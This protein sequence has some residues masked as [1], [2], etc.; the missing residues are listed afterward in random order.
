M[1][2][3]LPSAAW[4]EDHFATAAGLHIASGLGRVTGAVPFSVAEAGVAILAVGGAILGFR[5]WRASQ[6]RGRLAFRFVLAAAC[7]F[8]LG[9]AVF[10]GSWGLNYRR[11]PIAGAFGLPVEK[12]NADELRTLAAHFF[13]RMELARLAAPTRN[14]VA[15][16]ESGGQTSIFRRAAEAYHA[17]GQGFPFLSGDYSPAKPLLSSVLFSYAGVGGIYVPFTAE[18]HVNVDSPDWVLPFNVCHEMAHQRGVAREDEANYVGFRVARD[19]GSP[20]FVYSA[21]FG[22]DGHVVNALGKADPKM[23]RELWENRSPALKA[24]AA[25]Y[26]AWRATRTSRLA[27]VGDA[28]NSAYLRS[29]GVKDGVQSYGRVVDLLLAEQRAAQGSP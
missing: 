3:G 28:V 22:I 1:L 19:F 29:N 4:V 26:Q 14:G 5:A 25:A 2:S 8:S 16:V 11:E 13:E 7:V 15:T 18:P 21:Y 6:Q 17:A 23:A 9:Y 10:L 27:D 20:D 24:D 12:S